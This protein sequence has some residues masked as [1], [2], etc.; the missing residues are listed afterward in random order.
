MHTSY[1]ACQGC[2]VDPI[3]RCM[4]SCLVPVPFEDDRAFNQ[5]VHDSIALQAGSVNLYLHRRVGVLP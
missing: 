1:P 5:F 2:F 4:P 3:Y